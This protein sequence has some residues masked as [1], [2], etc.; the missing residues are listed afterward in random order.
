M[1]KFRRPFRRFVRRSGARSRADVQ[2]ISLCDNIFEVNNQGPDNFDCQHP[3]IQVTPLLT[4]V[5]PSGSLT[6]MFGETSGARGVSFLG[7][8]YQYWGRSSRMLGNANSSSSAESTVY[9]NWVKMPVDRAAPFTPLFLPNLIVGNPATATNTPIGDPTVDILHREVFEIFT[10]P[11]NSCSDPVCESPAISSKVATIS[12][13]DDADNLFKANQARRWFRDRVR[14]KRFL[15]DNETLFLFLSIVS[16]I[17][18]GSSA[19]LDIGIYGHLAMRV[20]W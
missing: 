1:R 6:Q 2:T 11:Q 12:R 16:G 8:N 13:W 9:L 19:F 7:A 3:L 20:R 17:P 10:P 18:Q 4:G 5:N 15:K 14:T